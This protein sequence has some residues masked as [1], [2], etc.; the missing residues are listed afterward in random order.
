[1][2]RH[3]ENA[4]FYLQW[5]IVS[6]VAFPVGAIAAASVVPTLGTRE[7]TLGLLLILALFIGLLL[8]VA[9]LLV[10]QYEAPS[11]WLWL[12]LTVAGMEAAT[13]ITGFWLV[14]AYRGWVAAGIGALAGA[15]LGLL[16]LPMIR[17]TPWKRGEWLAVTIVG[18]GVAHG[19]GQL[20]IREGN[21][22][23]LF[24]SVVQAQHAAIIGWAIGGL[25]AV[26]ILLFLTPIAKRREISGRIRWLP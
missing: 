26:F 17:E 9:Q 18:W 19:V 24:G 3:I 5:F 13:I 4:I 14:D 7:V 6:S 22:P 15:V 10:L 12:L 11:P 21:A 16:Q 2:N 1:M 20:F 8:G 23:G 25:L